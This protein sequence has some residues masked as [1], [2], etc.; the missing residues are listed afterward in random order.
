M[1]DAHVEADESRGQITRTLSLA[2]P[3]CAWSRSGGVSEN[4][5]RNVDITETK[6]TSSTSPKRR[7]K[8]KAP[9]Q[10]NQA[11][12]RTHGIA[13]RE[14]ALTQQTR[15]LQGALAQN[16]QSTHVALYTLNPF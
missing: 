8:P 6:K 13:R 4:G 5:A 10:T 11:L 12:A 15:L 3:S 1:R 9:L 14:F 16:T 7:Y 2:T